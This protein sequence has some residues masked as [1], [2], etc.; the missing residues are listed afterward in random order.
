MPHEP[1]AKRKVRSARSA[2]RNSTET[3]VASLIAIGLDAAE[4]PSRTH[5]AHDVPPLYCAEPDGVDR[6]RARTRTCRP[7]RC[8][9]RDPTSTAADRLPLAI[10]LAPRATY[11][12][13]HRVVGADGRRR[14]AR[15]AVPTRHGVGGQ[16][17][18]ERRPRTGVAVHE[19]AV[20][21]RPSMPDGRRRSSPVA[22]LTAHG[23]E[24]TR[25]PSDRGTS[26]KPR[27]GFLQYQIASS[28][29][30]PNA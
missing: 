8:R 23:S 6:G 22:S 21:D 19:A 5:D 9:S 16:R 7:G 17:A 4:E 27:P 11:A 15:S 14:S 24:S 2:P 13:P 26:P 12:H 25:P 10:P 20:P 3:P 30:R 18:A 28:A 1:L 29:P